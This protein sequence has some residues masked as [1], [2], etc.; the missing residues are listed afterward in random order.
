MG[1]SESSPSKMWAEKNKRGRREEKAH[2]CCLML[3][4][5]GFGS[6]EN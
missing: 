3:V 2:D 6:T 5:E 4:D 1:K